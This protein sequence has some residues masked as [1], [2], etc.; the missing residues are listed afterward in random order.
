MN[1]FNQIIRVIII[2]TL[3]ATFANSNQ[4]SAQNIQMKHW[5]IGGVDID[6]TSP[7]ASSYN[8]TNMV[9]STGRSGN[10]SG[11]YDN[12]GNMVFYVDDGTVYN[13]SGTEI[14]TLAKT[15]VNYGRVIECSIVPKPGDCSTYYVLYSTSEVYN[16]PNQAI[17]AYGIVT[18]SGSTIT[19]IDGSQI[20]GNT[21]SN[22]I[23]KC[24]FAVSNKIN[25]SGDRFLYISE[26]RNT[27][28]RVMRFLIDNTGIHFQATILNS[29][30][31]GNNV[32]Y[33]AFELDLNHNND[34]LAIGTL[35]GP[36]VINLNSSNGSYINHTTYSNES[37]NKYGVEFSPDDSKLFVANTVNILYVDLNTSTYYTVTGSEG[38]GYGQLELAYDGKIYCPGSGPNNCKSLDPVT[39]AFG[40]KTIPMHRVYDGLWN[41]GVLPDQID[42][43]VYD[44]DLR[45]MACCNEEYEFTTNDA[46]CATSATWT[47]ANNPFLDGQSNV[48][49][50]EGFII[51]PGTKV[52]ISNMNIAFGIDA[53]V[54]VE[55]GALLILDN[56]VFT[57]TTCPALWPGVEVWG[58]RTQSQNE[59]NSDGTNT[60][61]GRIIVTN[62]SEINNAHNAIQA[63]RVRPDGSLDWNKTGGIVQLLRN[64]RFMNNKKAVW[65][66]GYKNYTPGHIG[67]PSYELPNRGFINNCTFNTDD[68]FN[69]EMNFHAFIALY[70]GSKISITGNR[71]YN[72]STVNTDKKGTAIIAINSPMFV[73]SQNRFDGLHYGIKAISYDPTVSYDINDNDFNNCYNNIYM[74]NTWGAN[75]TSN[76]IS[77]VPKDPIMTTDPYGLYINGSTAFH[78]EDNTFNSD[79][80]P[81]SHGII[82]NNLGAL[83]NELYRNHFEGLNYGIKPQLCNKG[84]V[85]DVPQGLMLLCNDFANDETFYDILVLGKSMTNGLG[86]KYIGIAETQKIPATNNPSQYFYP[87]G[88]SFTNSHNGE[89]YDFDNIDAD[90][91]VYSHENN[92]AALRY[93]P[94]YSLNIGQQKLTPPE[95]NCPSKL[96]EGGDIS[97][98]SILLT[99]AQLALNSSII[100]RNIWKDGGQTD[101][102]EQVETTQPWDVYV[103][104]NNL[105]SKSPY[106]SDEVLMATIENPA[107]TSLM[108]KLIM[109]ANPQANRNEEIMEA[110]YNRIPALPQSYIDEIEA[111]ET[112]VSQ[113]EILEGNI[114]ANYHLVRSIENN[115]IDIYRLDTININANANMLNLM[116]SRPGLQDK[117]ILAA[118]YLNNAD[119]TN[120]QNVLNSIPSGFELD[121]KQFIEYQNNLTTF[122]IA[123]DFMENDKHIGDLTVTQIN[124]LQNIISQPAI[125]N[126]MAMALL[127]FNNPDYEIGELILYKPTNGARM[128]KPTVQQRPEIASLFNLFPNPAK[129]YFNLQYSSELESIQNLSIII[130]DMQGKTIKELNFKS[131]NIDQMIDVSEFA[132]GQYSVSLYSG[133]LLLEVKQLSIVR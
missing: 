6:F 69:G 120:M 83:E 108:V 21:S 16:V 85:N 52:T 60:H 93:K 122:G 66:G 15:G 3:M 115:I 100:I 117:Y 39:L 90:Y 56:T 62:N 72:T 131:R 67:D 101:L 128:A 51:G 63:I 40:E 132:M 74:N 105:I 106:L 18:V 2:I 49:T 80:F 87:A 57:G 55:P 130:T 104:F 28:G 78:I 8:T 17:L 124:S 10:S 34:M 107:F 70:A 42:G 81:G 59:W 79:Y 97:T 31:T 99:Q 126:S 75:I 77:V 47:P 9:A 43:H 65:I 84:K 88:N 25:A 86:Y 127:L 61:Q 27:Q 53:K 82:A 26:G 116:A 111:E 11:L 5:Y 37:S 12:N 30:M 14:I 96:G 129:D 91:L 50:S 45:Q 114:S 118:T 76:F 95:N 98:E 103:E 110:I 113:L 73:S 1:R 102:D 68:D 29:N 20:A 19:A 92:S 7:T 38:Y 119:Y 58:D 33:E 32:I 94:D 48:S 54:I 123:Q 36:T 89:T 24:A 23:D 13:S 41:I 121:E 133:S 46:F 35:D 22:T 112:T 4:L 125:D 109:V 44:Y 71:F 64:S